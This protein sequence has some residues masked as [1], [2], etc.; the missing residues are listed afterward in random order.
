MTQSKFPIHD[1]RNDDCYYYGKHGHHSKDFY[2]RKYNESRQRNIRHNGNFVDKD[3]SISDGFKN[4]KLFLSDAVLSMENDAVNVSF[5]DSRESLH[6]SCNK[7]WFDEYYENIYETYVYLGD[8]KSVKIQGYGEIG[9]NFPNGKERHILNVMY[10]FGIR[11]NLIF[12]S[13]ISDEDL[14]VEFLKS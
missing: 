1:K 13:T 7:E 9:V 11:K 10:V 12:V 4:L 8:N 6:M 2:K 5:I 14:K 3:T